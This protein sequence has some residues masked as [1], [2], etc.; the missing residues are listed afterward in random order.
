MTELA[1]HRRNRARAG[2]AEAFASLVAEY[3]PDVLRLCTLIMVDR[4]LAEDAAQN[5]WRQAWLQIHTVRELSSLRPWLLRVAANEA[6]QL[7]RRNRRH[8]AQSL[9]TAPVVAGGRDPGEDVGLGDALRTLRPEDREL[10]GMRHV[11]GMNSIEIGR[12]IGISP[13]GVRTRL[14]R[15]RAQ[16]QQEL[17]D[18]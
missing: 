9:E 5:A 13:E 14:K 1:D 6:K 11:V 4:S 7:L 10:L 8:F 3:G 18:G 17:G 2:D 12:L 15:I 16:L